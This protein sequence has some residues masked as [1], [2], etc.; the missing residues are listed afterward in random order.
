DQYAA[1]DI[2]ELVEVEYEPLDSVMSPFESIEDETV[3]HEDVGTNVA[4]GERFEFGA[5][6]AAFEEADHVVQRE[7]SYGRASGVPIET[8]GTI[9]EYHPSEDTFTIDANLQ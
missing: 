9:G 6:E 5:P 7:F 4:D 1:E 8:A 2:A 3:L